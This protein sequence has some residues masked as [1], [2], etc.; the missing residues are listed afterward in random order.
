MRHAADG[1]GQTVGCKGSLFQICFLIQAGFPFP[2]RE[3]GKPSIAQLEWRVSIRHQAGIASHPQSPAVHAHNKTKD[4]LVVSSGEQHHHGSNN[5]K[6]KG[7]TTV[8]RPSVAV[9]GY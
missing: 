6:D 9:N 2:L 4:V 8:A 5:D 7:Q 1:G 3:S